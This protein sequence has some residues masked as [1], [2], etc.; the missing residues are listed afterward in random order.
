MVITRR[1]P[2]PVLDALDRDM[3]I[4]GGRFDVHNEARVKKGYPGTSRIREAA[5]GTHPRV[6]IEDL[7]ACLFDVAT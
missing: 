1:A 7:Q 4:S 2:K 6:C 5:L 3:F